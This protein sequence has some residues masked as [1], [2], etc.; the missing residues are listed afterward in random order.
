M[1]EE[2]L[3]A[4][5]IAAMAGDGRAYHALLTISADRLRAYFRRRLA[6]REEDVEDLVQETL[7]AIHRK[8]ASYS[9]SLPFTHWLYGIA[10]YRIIDLYRREGRRPTV[11][12]GDLDFAVD[13]EADSV[14][15][16]IDIDRLLADLPVK[17]ATAIR[18]TKVDGFS[19][20]EA[21]ERSGQ[22]EPAVKANVQRGLKRLIARVQRSR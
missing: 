3:R 1:S 9:P 20:R 13:E 19:T 18:L 7:V 15:A 17:Q 14:M 11:P 21:A 4:L 16:S 8:R 6:G 12:L 2:R 10:R 22:S 5:M